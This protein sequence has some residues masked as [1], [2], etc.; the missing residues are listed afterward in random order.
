TREAAST[1]AGEATAAATAITAAAGEAAAAE[2]IAGEAAAGLSESAL[3]AV[4]AA[5]TALVELLHLL[6]LLRRKLI[7]LAWL[8][9]L[10]AAGQLLIHLIRLTAAARAEL[11]G[12]ERQHAHDAGVGADHGSQGVVSGVGTGFLELDDAHLRIRNDVLQID[13]FDE[14]FH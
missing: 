12:I 9:T 1:T 8:L 13:H 5:A 14:I 7:L 10:T 6:K 11:R 4:A 2:L 3:A